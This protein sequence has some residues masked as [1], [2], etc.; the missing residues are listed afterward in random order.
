MPDFREKQIVFFRPEF[1]KD[2]RLRI[3][4]QNIALERDGK[5]V[6]QVAT[7]KALSVF[8]LGEISFTSVLLRK[9]L[10]NGVSVFCLKRNLETY[11][12]VGAAA[13]GNYLLREKQYALSPERNMEIA[14]HIVQNKIRNQI[15]LLRKRNTENAEAIA[16]SLDDV[17]REMNVKIANTIERQALLGLEGGMSRRFFRE[18]FSD[19]GWRRRIPK[20]KADPEN[21]LLDVGYSMLFN[22][23]DSLLRLFGFDTYR[24]VYHQ[25][26]FQRK[27]LSCDIEEPFRCII[28]KKLLKMYHLGQVKKEDFE[29]AP[30]RKQYYLK[31]QESTRYA[32]LF[33]EA[34]LERKEEIYSY[35]RDFYYAVLNETDE[36]PY[37]DIK[38]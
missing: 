12:T 20:G 29:Y 36:L 19:I 33:T 5:V 31:Y 1:G 6:N 25:L 27:S 4:N 35:V 24:G 38:K 26:F 9:C 28:E 11:A 2:V 10:E 17:E 30:K 7:E 22:Y 15:A 16:E 37:F 21:I 32:Q 14:R 23:V 8:V 34:I 3:K 13:E 18:Y